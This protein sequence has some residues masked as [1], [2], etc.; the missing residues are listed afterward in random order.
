[1]LAIDADRPI[2]DA[3]RMMKECEVSQLPVNSEGRVV[4]QVDE[5]SLL[6]V[7]NRG[8][9][10]ATT[11]VRDAMGLAPPSL[12]PGVSVEEAYRVLLSGHPGILV[13]E[14]GEPRGYV[15][16]IDLVRFWAEAGS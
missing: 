5:V 9:S 2:R 10:P 7:L 13:A 6:Q 14:G 15:T 8:G 11:T 4:G 1:M 3:I 12:E 16:R